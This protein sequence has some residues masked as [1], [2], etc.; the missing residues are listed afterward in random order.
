[1]TD[2]VSED[3]IEGVQVRLGKVT[4]T[5]PPCGFD[6]LEKHAKGI[7]K[8]FGGTAQS[9]SFD[10]E[11]IALVIDFAHGALRLNYPQ[12]TRETVAQGINL[13]NVQVLIRAALSQSLP[14]T[15]AGLVPEPQEH[16]EATPLGESTGGN[17]GQP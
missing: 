6:T 11:K 14:P 1:M 4:Y 5:M 12:I 10:A 7:E 8:H 13:Q 2:V 9:A 3:L 15:P 16:G 17:S